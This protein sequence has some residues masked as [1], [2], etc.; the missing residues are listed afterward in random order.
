VIRELIKAEHISFVCLQETKR[1][2]ISDFDLLQIVGL[3][4][5]YFYLPARHTHGGILVAWRSS[6]WVISNTLMRQ[7]S[8]SA[9]VFHASGGPKCWL[10][11][12]YGPANDVDKSAFLEELH[13]LQQIRLVPWLICGDFNMIYRVLDKNNTRLDRRRMGQFWRFL[14]ELVLK[15][16]HLEGRLFTW[17]NERSHLTLKK[18][19]SVFINAEWDSKFPDHDLRSL[20]SLCSNHAPLL[21]CTDRNFRSKKRFMFRSFWP[22]I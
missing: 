17:S 21:L 14:N 12:V 11:S 3:S 4:F 18:I 19:D 16:I 10:A 5:D 9:R 13:E 22:S 7:F 8:V 15:E 2:V 1:D 6:A 20:T